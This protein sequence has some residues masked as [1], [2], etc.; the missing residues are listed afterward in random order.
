MSNQP[1]PGKMTFVEGIGDEVLL[2]F[3]LITLGVVVVVGWLST[4]V[5]P[6]WIPRNIWLVRMEST[7]N[8]RVLE[9][10]FAYFFMLILICLLLSPYV[11]W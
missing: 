9:V 11:C 2:F 4:Y 3:L 10:S 6:T 7:Q 5:R 1:E 8:R